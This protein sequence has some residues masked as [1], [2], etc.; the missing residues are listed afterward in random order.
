MVALATAVGGAPAVAGRNDDKPGNLL[1]GH[2]QMILMMDSQKIDGD[3]IRAEVVSTILTLL[4]G[5][6]DLILRRVGELSK[7]E[8]HDATEEILCA[9]LN[10]APG[11]TRSIQL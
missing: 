9:W 1:C 4:E 2:T 10:A 7:P 11:R 5:Q 8:L 6:T 3:F